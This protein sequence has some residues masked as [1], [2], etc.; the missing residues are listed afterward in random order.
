M[1]EKGA[2]ANGNS[3]LMRALLDAKKFIDHPN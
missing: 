3:C 2:S 1:L